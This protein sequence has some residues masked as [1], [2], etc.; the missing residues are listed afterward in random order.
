MIDPPT[1]FHYAV[2]YLA[3]IVSLMIILKFFAKTS[4]EEVAKI[5]ILG[6]MVIWIAP[7]IDIIFG[8]VGGHLMGYLIIPGK[9]LWL[10]FITFFG[11]HIASGIT[12]GIQIETILGIIFCYLYVYTVTKNNMRATAA[13]VLFYCLIF[14]L[15]STPSL[16]ALFV[17]G[18]VSP[19]NTIVNSA[20]ASHVVQNNIHPGFTST[21][22]G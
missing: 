22:L 21:V 5:C 8:G 9:E 6:F 15:V 4:L 7:I 19:I 12:L 14:F 17:P 10:R 13:A 20:V 2:F 3:T 1:I 11:G 18:N 16:I